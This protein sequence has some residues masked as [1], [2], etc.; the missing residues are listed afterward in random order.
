[1]PEALLKSMMTLNSAQLSKGSRVHT[2]ALCWSGLGLQLC[3]RVSRALKMELSENRDCA[4]RE[5]G[6]KEG[7]IEEISLSSQSPASII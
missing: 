5:A 3:N 1:L 4:K 2:E 7:L 6:H